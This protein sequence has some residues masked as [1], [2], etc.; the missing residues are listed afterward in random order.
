MKRQ[1]IQTGL[2]AFFSIVLIVFGCEMVRAE[3]GPGCDHPVFQVQGCSYP[4]DGGGVD[5]QDGQDGQDG[6]QGPP[7][8]A[9]PPGPQGPQG[10]KGDPGEVDYAEVNRLIIEQTSYS[11]SKMNSF[12]AAS[13]VLDAPLPLSYGKSR[14]SFQGASVWGTM[15]LGMGYS[16]VDED[17]IG[18]QF[19]YGTSSG[20]DSDQVIKLGISVEF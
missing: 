8:P 4:T 16:Y 12:L 6:E 14:L 5:G 10:P 1:S 18:L 11:F 3:D 13:S 7:G 20:Q 17:G 19:A 15:A 9:G 2:L